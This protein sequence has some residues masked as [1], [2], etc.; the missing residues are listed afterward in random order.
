MTAP[1]LAI[2]IPIYRHSTLAQEAIDCALSLTGGMEQVVIAVDD[3]CPHAETR[4]A[5]RNWAMIEPERFHHIHQA[6][7]GLSGARN[8]GIRFALDRYPGL[9]AIYLLDADN[10][11]ED[12]S[13]QLFKG[14]LA[15]HTDVD[16]F[17]PNFDM[18]GL[19]ANEHNGGPFS[20]A[21]LAESNICEAGSLIRTR[22]F[23][24]GVR[25]DEGMR[26][27]YEDW[28]FWL[29]A[30]REGFRGMPVRQSFLRYRK[31]PESMLSGSHDSDVHLRSQI[32][33]RH[34]WLYDRDTVAQYAARQS[35]RFTLFET[36]S[37]GRVQRF[38]DPSAVT[39]SD[40]DTALQGMLAAA[41]RP[42]QVQ[43]PM[44]W[45]VAR[46]GVMEQLAEMKLAASALWHLHTSAGPADIAVLQ[47]TRHPD[48][49]RE[50]TTRL[51]LRNP[52]TLRRWRRMSPRERA[53]A[54]E[55][56]T[57]DKLDQAAA[58]EQADIIL[59]RTETLLWLTDPD[60]PNA[61]PKAKPL[62][63][64]ITSR[65]IARITLEADDPAPADSPAPLDTFKHLARQ[66]ADSRKTDSYLPALT[67]WRDRPKVSGPHN[68][69]WI[70]NNHTMG[71]LPLPLIREEG[72]VHIGFVLP[73][74]L[75]GGVE[76]CVVA[77]ATALKRQ[78]VKCNLFVYGTGAMT[79]TD[80]M[81]APFETVHQISDPSLRDW[82]GKPFM[83]TNMASEPGET[84][85]RD[86]TAS[87]AGMNAVIVSGCA[88]AYYGFSAL[89]AKGIR[90]LTWEHL[91]ERGIYG[92]SYGTPYLA[93]AYEGAIDTILTCS[94]QLRDW[95]HGQGV[96]WDKLLA[97]PNGPGFPLS[98]DAQAQALA[99]RQARTPDQPLR[100]G[101][102]GRFD[103]QKGA[104]RFVEVATACRDLPIAFSITGG[105]VLGD[106][107]ITLPPHI[108]RHPAAFD[109]TDLEAAFARLDILLMPSRDEGLPLTIMEAQRVGVVPVATDVG[110]VSEAMEDG[111]D[112]FLI[113]GD[114][115]VGQMI[116]LLTR[117]AEDR[118]RVSQIS[119]SAA[120]RSGQWEA[121]ATAVLDCLNRLSPRSESAQ[122]P[123]A[124]LPR[125]QDPRPPQQ[126][127]G[128]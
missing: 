108:T 50:L 73:I 53:L 34:K 76:K 48:G 35:P 94:H 68:F 74:F 13:L 72:E 126:K 86:M 77:L 122:T 56:F 65:R 27:G 31:R 25:F 30:A 90:T 123:P 117:L 18:F 111:V 1:T 70:L 64:R 36:G 32:R 44:A 67:P 81:L 115:V 58:L 62:E 75:F 80:W 106:G 124:G 98:E 51:P 43:R 118:E 19:R 38:T 47:S 20:V 41:I 109:L 28:E 119:R 61:G 24:A 87:L 93:V 54:K 71:S 125:V 88:A 116:T 114:D 12:H 112:G 127:T 26:D 102:L 95:L 4:A 83:G 5:L 8:T 101:F 42:D 33:K 15:T 63:E 103:D 40:E 99:V 78:G 91:L 57:A 45:V 55:S 2:V 6:N 49:R 97:L 105:S 11:L 104:D 120:V 121:N 39:P 22:V 46:S 113:Q 84:M 9:E 128:G 85:L 92:R 79:G 16:W 21:Q 3:G 52:E 7:R 110:A 60:A 107:G 29:S 10:L 17:Y 96:P 59:I 23:T 69:H 66:L 82:S 37:N 89:R 100:V 14:L